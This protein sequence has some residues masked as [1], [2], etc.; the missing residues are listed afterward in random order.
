MKNRGRTIRLGLRLVLPFGLGFLLSC[1]ILALIV[2]GSEGT[3]PRG[4]CTFV[5]GDSGLLPLD[6]NDGGAHEYSCSVD[7]GLAVFYIFSMGM[8]ISAV[9]FLVPG[10][11]SV[12][13]RPLRTRGCRE[14]ER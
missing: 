7:L 11:L 9:F 3:E 2:T 1:V 10:A 13:L 6:P 4:V 14:N 8:V 12:L 5:A